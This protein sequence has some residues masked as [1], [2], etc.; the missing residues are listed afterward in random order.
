VRGLLRDNIDLLARNVTENA[1]RTGEHYI[2][3]RRSELRSMFGS[4]AG[5]GLI[6]GF[7]AL[8][9]ILLSYLHAR[10]AVEALLFSMNYSLGFM[11]VHVL[12]FT[13]ATKQPA[14]T[15]A[16]IAAALHEGTQGGSRAIDVDS[17]AALVNKVF[18]T[19]IVA[20]LG[21][22]ATD[23]PDRLPARARPTGP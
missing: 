21:N 3:E 16:R 13:I 18:R 23:D 8:F 4:A 2:A 22:L 19:Q 10:A 20:V 12:H 17:M 9:K 14:M 6:V 5:A 11:L 1:S 7:M 15:A